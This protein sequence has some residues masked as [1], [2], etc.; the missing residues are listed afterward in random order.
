MHQ[1]NPDVIPAGIG[2]IEAGLREIGSRQHSNTTP[3][4]KGCRRRLSAAEIRHIQPKKEGSLRPPIPV[5]AV[6]NCIGK[7]KILAVQHTAFL[8]VVLVAPGRDLHML[9]G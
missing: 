5:A 3:F 9:H 6:K 8:N 4:P 7:V 2:T 1:R